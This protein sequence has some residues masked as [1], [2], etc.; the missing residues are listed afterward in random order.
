MKHELVRQGVA[1]LLAVIAL[2]CL[3]ISGMKGSVAG[4]VTGLAMLLIG[5]V[6]EIVEAIARMCKRKARG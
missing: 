6:N 4:M 5:S 1:L 3:V 2:P